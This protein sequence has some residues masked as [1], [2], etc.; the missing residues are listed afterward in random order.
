MALAILVT[1]PLGALDPSRPI[2]QYARSAWQTEAGLPQNSVTAIAET[3][4]GFVWLATSEGLARFDGIRFRV[5]DKTTDPV[6]PDESIL[7]LQIDDGGGLL[8]GTG[9]G[10]V[11][12]RGGRFERV[13]DDVDS[14]VSST[15]H[16]P[17]GAIWLATSKG[18]FVR[19]SGATQKVRDGDFRCLL[20]EDGIVWAGSYGSGLLRVDT[21]GKISSWTIRDGLPSDIVRAVVRDTEGRLWIGT[22]GG[23]ATLANDTIARAPLTDALPHPSVRALFV[24]REANLWV[25]TEGGLARITKG[26][27]SKFTG[28]D[29][30]SDDLVRSF[31]ESSDG[32]LWVG[33]L[34]G[35]V[36]RFRDGPVVPWGPPEGLAGRV[37]RTIAASA[38][39]TIWIG[40]H[41]GGLHRLRDGTVR[42]FGIADGLRNQSVYSLL[43]ED[44]TLWIGTS[45]G[46]HRLDGDRISHV[47]GPAEFEAHTIHAIA[48]RNEREIVMGGPGGFWS[49][50]GLACTR[51]ET[52]GTSSINSIVRGRDRS[53]W[54]GTD[55][56]LLRWDGGEAWTSMREDFGDALR[57]GSN[58][59]LELPS[60]LVVIASDS[61]GLLLVRANNEAPK[62][63]SKAQGL[64]DDLVYRVIDDGH[65]SLWMSC[66]RGIY[67][68][69]LEEIEEFAAGARTSVTPLLLGTSHGMRDAECNGGSQPAGS[70]APDGRVW[71]P[72]V[73]GAVV[74]APSRV[75][76]NQIA[77]RVYVEGV[78]VDGEFVDP[79]HAAT[80]EAGKKS[81]SFRFVAL[82]FAAPGATRYRYKL[83]PQSTAWNDLG[84][85]REVAVYIDHPGDYTFAVTA[86]NEH[87]VWNEPGAIYRFSVAPH[88]WERPSVQSFAL[89]A[90]LGA[91]LIGHRARTRSLRRRARELNRVVDE[92]TKELQEAKEKVEEANRQL[93]E[94]SRTD[95][96]T[97]IANRRR[98]DERLAEEWRRGARERATLALVLVDVDHFK[99]FNDHH[100]HT[101]G[102][103]CL[104]SVAACLSFCV[105]RPDDLV[106]RF[107]GEEFAILLPATDLQGATMIAERA[108]KAVESLAIRHGF[109]PTFPQV[110]ISLGIAATTPSEQR[111]PS[112]I[113][114]LADAAL[115]RAKASG[116]NRVETA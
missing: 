16:T 58:D 39:G 74:V 13:L 7:S 67:A 34:G 37:A 113:L 54:I 116:R 55:D 104:R 93:S 48:R 78:T 49:W 65:G 28:R 100:G 4:D 94:L 90:F 46:L 20:S 111:S 77:P 19:R 40:S 21:A 114:E 68:V 108:R 6:L 33:T 99:A 9:A 60:G 64:P 69:A 45:G 10:V 72:T 52:P 98:F 84:E 75:E 87:G 107:G 26:Q 32:S 29:G 61:S 43:V 3:P 56:D 27:V 59:V 110:T 22:Q 18:L 76:R 53:F 41:D 36:N 106:A 82:S 5:Y 85:M 11:I 38:D 112:E 12:R 88:L 24:D 86:C 17:D 70:L 115:Y 96:L 103:T 62:R 80:F 23:L 31:F 15:R 63:L 79:S 44:H 8:V 42:N 109:S 35:G 92:R 14:I 73:E 30:L 81:I 101:E 71:F 91:L 83:H 57:T 95:A 1:A 2:T 89:V 102:D 47:P 25:G 50:N 66:N 51:I 97:G 105:H